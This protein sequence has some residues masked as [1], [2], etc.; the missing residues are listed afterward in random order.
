MQ[1]NYNSYPTTLREDLEILAKNAKNPFLTFNEENCIKT[2][3]S[4]KKVLIFYVKTARKILN[5]EN[6]G[7]E[8]A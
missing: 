3:I 5:L 2:R 4:D 1:K 6:M 7:P 8:L